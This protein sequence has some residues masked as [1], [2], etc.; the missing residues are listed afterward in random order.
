MKTFLAALFLALAVFLRADPTATPSPTPAAT[1]SPAA[2]RVTQYTAT[3]ANGCQGALYNVAIVVTLPPGTL[4]LSMPTRYSTVSEDS[5][6]LYI[7]I[8]GLPANAAYPFS[9]VVA[10][11]AGQAVTWKIAQALDWMGYD[12]SSNPCLSLGMKAN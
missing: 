12:W 11:P 9:A 3:L 6:A 7:V 5:Q 8:P 4:I 1:P 2:L 10:V